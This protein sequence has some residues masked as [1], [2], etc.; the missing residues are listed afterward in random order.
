VFPVVIKF[1][2][3]PVEDQV[4]VAP[5]VIGFIAIVA[6][7]RSVTPEVVIFQLNVPL[8]LAGTRGYADRVMGIEVGAPCTIVTGIMALCAAALTCPVCIKAVTTR[9]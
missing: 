9:E 6:D 5:V 7:T 8:P 4:L 2:G 3:V 1:T